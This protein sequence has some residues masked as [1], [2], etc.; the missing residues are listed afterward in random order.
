MLNLTALVEELNK[1]FN[2]ELKLSEDGQWVIAPVASIIKLLKVLK[3]EQGFKMLIDI[4]A[5]DYQGSFEVVYHVMRL[6][7]AELL[8][9]KITLPAE[10]PNVPT[11]TVVW[12]A[13][14]VM[15]REIFDLMGLIFNG[16]ENLTRILCPDNFSGHPLRKDFNPDSKNKLS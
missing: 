16:H 9:V 14:D 4:T 7:D 1:Q 10:K 6:E 5:V 11:A 8:R 13:A 3:E 15:E 12:K 2:G